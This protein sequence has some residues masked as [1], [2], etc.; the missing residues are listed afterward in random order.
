MLIKDVA[1]GNLRGI[2]DCQITNLG[3][4]NVITGKNNA[5]KSTILDSFLLLSSVI[6]Y[7][8]DHMASIVNRRSDR[9]WDAQEL[10]YKYNN[11]PLIIE[12]KLDNEEYIEIHTIKESTQSGS[13]S[14]Y[15]SGSYITSE[16]KLKEI[17]QETNRSLRDNRSSNV[18]NRPPNTRKIGLIEIG[19]DK[20]SIPEEVLSFLENISL[21]DPVIKSRTGDLET[22][23]DEIKRN[24]KYDEAL[25]VLKETYGDELR[26]WELSRYFNQG[27]GENR[28]AFSYRGGRPVYVDDIGDGMKIGFAAITRAYTTQNS[29]LLI[30]E[31]ETYQHPSALKKLIESLVEAVLRSNLQLVVTTHSPDVLRYFI[32]VYPKTRVFFVE[33]DPNEDTVSVNDQEDL[34]SIFRKLGLDYGELL[35]YEKLAVIEGRE[36]YLI[37]DDLFEKYSGHKLDSAG[38]DL[39]ALRGKSNF[40]EVVRAFAIS[41]KPIIIIKDLDKMQDAQEILNQVKNYLLTLSKEGFI[42]E[43]SADNIIVKKSDNGIK[44]IISKNSIIAAGNLDL[45]KYESHSLTDYLL[46]L[47]VSNPLVYSE[48]AKKS[49]DN[50]EKTSKNSK[51]EIKSIFGE[52]TEEVIKKILQPVTKNM[53]PLKLIKDILEPLEKIR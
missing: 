37:I 51:E 33:K 20:I 43:E 6:F 14:F 24:E 26:G 5:G 38:I 36:D 15:L 47:V 27:S 35:K 13:F 3:Q 44:W 8:A 41:N 48:I 7:P 10:L 17:S 21:I 49:I 30:E 23:Y 1:I 40:S 11:H 52:Y 29:L 50:Y 53:I 4:I 19:K 16:I 45:N 18:R 2:K 25:K 12:F 46:E 28:T 42:V 34:L 32:G 9:S 31:I 22:K 39:L